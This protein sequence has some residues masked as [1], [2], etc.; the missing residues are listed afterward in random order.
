MYKVYLLFK[1][2][3]HTIAIYNSNSNDIDIPYVYVN[4]L[5]DTTIREIAKYIYNVDIDYMIR[6]AELEAEKELIYI[7]IISNTHAMKFVRYHDSFH[8]LPMTH[9]G[10]QLENLTDTCKLIL[11]TAHELFSGIDVNNYN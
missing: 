3:N 5:L 8:Y 9:G 10:T 6:G 11:E 7:V 4:D 2:D 1:E